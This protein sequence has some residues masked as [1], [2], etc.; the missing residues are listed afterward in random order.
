MLTILVAC[1]GPGDPDRGVVDADHDG[2]A[3]P[4]DCDDHDATVFP[5]AAD[6]AGDG[7]DQDCD[8]WDD[9]AEATL[10][11]A[12]PDEGF[13]SRVVLVDGDVGV[14]APFGAD[15]G[16]AAGRVYLDETPVGD[17]SDGAFL[18]AGLAA[19]DD[20]TFVAGA[21]GIGELRLFPAGDL[22]LASPGVGG[23]VAARGTAWVASTPTGAVGSDGA[24]PSW[25]CRPDA[26]ALD[27]T[28]TVWA[29]F[30]HGDA[31]VRTGSRSVAR[32]G[33]DDEAG[34]AL[35]FADID[36][37]G[38]EDLVV[39]APGAGKL[40]VL[41]PAALPSTLTGAPAVTLGS[42]RFG[43]A[44]ALGSDGV[45]YVGAPMAGDDVEGVVYAVVNGAPVEVARGAAPGDQL[46]TALAAGRGAVVA[47]APGSAASTGSVR[48]V[49][50]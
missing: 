5:G 26:L 47:G 19:L 38:T 41:D 48:I 8:G 35:L 43:A 7:L 21:P 39:G 31:A 42:G 17:G 16:F 32:A 37:D 24:T 4:L 20:A 6:P 2:V 13:G 11:G 33:A 50:P 25:D 27:A 46:G 18:G 1:N 44:L 30:S 45:L 15:G 40:Y 28:G 9:L 22:L 29:G 14:G 10:A 3:A 49:V 34:Y 23:V 12:R 36:G